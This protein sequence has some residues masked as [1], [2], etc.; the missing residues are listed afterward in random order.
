MTQ[1]ANFK[2][3][4][5][6]PNS[7]FNIRKSHKISS[8]TTL[9]F[10]SYQPKT[11]RGV[12]NTP[13]VP[14]GLIPFCNSLDDSTFRKLLA[15]MFLNRTPGGKYADDIVIMSRSL[16]VIL[17]CLNEVNKYCN[18]WNLTVNT[19]KTEAMIITSKNKN[20]HK[21]K[22]MFHGKILDNV[23]EFTYLYIK[24]NS[25]GST[26]PTLSHISTNAE[27]A[28][29]TLNN[30]YKLNRLPIKK[31]LKLFESCIHPVLPHGS[32]V[33]FPLRAWTINGIP[34]PLNWPIFSYVNT[35]I[36]MNER[37]QIT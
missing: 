20:N 8:G 25:T 26:K 24:I 32:E 30:R 3:F 18:S 22:F 4:L 10:R 17:S 6:C 35:S 21:T 28:I 34:L 36:S 27:Q 31:V 11:S 23:T 14:L 5:F 9:Y 29:F 13:P 2:N 33:G 12:E 7:T 15:E 16:E 1:D 19:T 37:L